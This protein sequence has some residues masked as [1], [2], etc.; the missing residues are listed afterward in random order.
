MLDISGLKGRSDLRKHTREPVGVTPIKEVRKGKAIV[1]S[2]LFAESTGEMGKRRTS[3]VLFSLR[4]VSGSIFL[5]KYVFT[6][7]RPFL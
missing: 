7:V 4:L 2:R 1:G 6:R 3:R 5:K